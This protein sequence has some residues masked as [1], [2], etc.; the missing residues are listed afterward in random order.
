[1]VWAALFANLFTPHVNLAAVELA[2]AAH[3]RDLWRSSMRCN[4]GHSHEAI[5]HNFLLV[6]E[7]AF[8]DLFIYILYG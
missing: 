1:M 6:I 7:T 5:C 4:R 8:V 2:A 3:L